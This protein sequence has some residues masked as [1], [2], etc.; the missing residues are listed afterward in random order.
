MIVQQLLIQ[1]SMLQEHFLKYQ[2][3][4][5]PFPSMLPKNTYAVIDHAKLGQ[6]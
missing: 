6:F 5:V 2:Y 3:L 4:E 1:E